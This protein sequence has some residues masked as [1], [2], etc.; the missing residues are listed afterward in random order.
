MGQALRPI[1]SWYK[2]EVVSKK[3]MH[4]SD[5]FFYRPLK[6]VHLQLRLVG[7]EDLHKKKNE[8]EDDFIVTVYLYL[9]SY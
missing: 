3:K 2:M 7:Y 9:N 8:K 5:Y 1:W 4:F 6:L